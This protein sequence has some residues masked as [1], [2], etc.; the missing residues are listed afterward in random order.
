[1]SLKSK[2]YI[3]NFVLVGT[4][5][6]SWF[7]HESLDRRLDWWTVNTF[8]SSRYSYK[9]SKFNLSNILPQIDNNDTGQDHI[10][11]TP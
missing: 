1:M 8:F 6:K 10:S 4:I 5:D 9:E 3:K 2:L 11:S 7:T